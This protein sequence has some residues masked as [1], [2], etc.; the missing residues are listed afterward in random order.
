MLTRSRGF[1]RAR[2]LI[3]TALAPVVVLLSSSAEARGQQPS[4]GVRVRVVDSSGKGIGGASVEL[5]RG[6]STRVANGTTDNDGVAAVRAPRDEDLEVVVRRIGFQ[7]RSVFFRSDSA[8]RRFDLALQ[9]APVSLAAVDVTA[10]RDL[11][12]ARYHV[13]ADDIAQSARPIVDGLDVVLKLRPDMAKPP[14]DGIYSHCGL[15]NVFVNGQRIRYAPI[16]DGLAAKVRQERMAALLAMAPDRPPH[17]TTQALVPLSIQSVLATIRPE[18]IE[19]MNYVGCADTKSTDIVRAQN[20]LFVVLKP[21]VAYE[22]GRGSYVVATDARAT[23][24]SDGASVTTVINGSSKNFRSRIVGV[25]DED[26][27]SPL[28]DVQVVDVRSATFAT[29]TASGTVSL[30]FLP[31]GS[32]EVALRRAGY[33]DLRLTVMISPADTMPLTLTLHPAKKPK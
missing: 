9:P 5:I 6:L 27:G 21:G 12:R 16:D 3:A 19:E 7:R 2:R 24:A 1:G 14:N 33:D 23:A 26:T 13:D 10:S 15:Y 25:F 18:H 22:P 17:Y 32:N 20:G 4:I 28:A 31:E 30:V 8:D 29:T 11:N